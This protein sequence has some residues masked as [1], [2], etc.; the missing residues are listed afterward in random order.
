MGALYQV[1]P[2]GAFNILH[3]FSGSDGNEPEGGLVLGPDGKLYG[4]TNSGGTSGAYG[5]R[6]FRDDHRDVCHLVRF[7]RPQRQHTPL[8][9]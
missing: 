1:T 2:A 9:A 4:T 7:H 8:M 3:A 5:Y 6:V